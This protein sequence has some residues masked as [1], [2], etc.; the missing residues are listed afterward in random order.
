M[1]QQL[2]LRHSTALT[3][4]PQLQQAI[5]L[6]Q[7]SYHEL[8]AFLQG[9]LEQNPFLVREDD[10]WA[11]THLDLGAESPPTSEDFLSV[12]PPFSDSFAQRTSA[13]LNDLTE[14]LIPANKCTLQE[15]LLQQVRTRFIKPEE[16]IIAAALVPMVQST[17]Y[18][19]EDLTVIAQKL[20]VPLSQLENIL[21]AMQQFDPSGVFARHLR[22]CLQIQ[23]QDA[24]LFNETYKKL[25]LNLELVAQGKLE[26]L[27]S[28][29][30]VS[31]MTICHM[32]QGVRRLNPKPG[33][34]FHPESSV[35]MTPEVFVQWE[36]VQERWSIFL[37]PE[38]MPRVLINK[39]Y[40]ASVRSLKTGGVEKKYLAEQ[41]NHANWLIKALHQRSMTL[42]RVTTEIVG[43]QNDFFSKGISYIKP[44][45]LK[46]V[47]MVLGLHES[48]I[49]RV[50][51][52]KYMATPRGTFELKFFFSSTLDSQ[53]GGIS[54][55][56]VRHRI[57][58]IIQLEPSDH[59]LSDEAIALLLQKEGIVI[60]R[61]TVAKYRE[62]LRLPPAFQRKRHGNFIQKDLR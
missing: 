8:D 23:L 60:A 44:L 45:I 36:P 5:Q 7:L 1:D 26:K 25:L 11:P 30:G 42:L 15:H 3:M 55:E 37:N 48:T 17:G 29:C 24:G 35:N 53:E 52:H 39:S 12:G 2:S 13:S 33:L 32:L 58:Q 56:A 14:I 27:A 59:P 21:S 19:E 47:A 51:S 31:Q 20:S 4:T 6:L 10:A 18:F 22:E 49:S 61:R 50:T 62:N 41:I 28:K 9:H 43:Q 54:S 40:V 34:L 16:R 57:Q 46:D 38:T